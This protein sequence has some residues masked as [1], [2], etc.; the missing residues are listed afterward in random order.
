MSNVNYFSPLRSTFYV[1]DL[2]EEAAEKKHALTLLNRM[3]ITILIKGY[4]NRCEKRLEIPEFL[5]YYKYK[6]NPL[7]LS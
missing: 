3:P 4:S 6:K 2:E 5:L 7:S 1:V